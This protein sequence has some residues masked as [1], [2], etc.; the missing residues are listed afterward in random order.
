MYLRPKEV[1]RCWLNHTENF[2]T[3]VTEVVSASYPNL[4][5]PGRLRYPL[6]SPIP[7]VTDVENPTGA[8]NL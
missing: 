3:V 7:D 1:I 8:K 6:R 5:A 2:L 4:S